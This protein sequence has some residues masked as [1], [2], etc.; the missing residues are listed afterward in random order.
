MQHLKPWLALTAAML[1][2][3]VAQADTFKLVTLE[4]PP[5]EYTENGEV[6]GLAVEVVRAAFK[7]MNH[8]VV[9]ESYPWARSQRMFEQG[10]ADGIFTYFKN[11]Q[12]EEYA[13]FGKEPVV[14][15]TVSLW[16]LRDSKI[17]FTGDLNK[18]QSY[19]FGVVNT[20]S[21]G[22]RF[23]AAVKYELLRTDVAHSIESCISKL[24]AGRTDIW[25][26]NRFGAIHELKRFGKLDQV[27]E[28]KLPV[29]EVPAYVGFSKLRNHTALRDAFD[30]ALATLKQTGAY[31]KLVKKYAE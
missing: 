1:F 2:S 30:Q 28:L 24:L 10:Q 18:L 20:V 12:R 7:L 27:K 5:Y 8:E 29:Q 15:Q 23:D 11:P 16:V 14:T 4:Y 25:V 19:S 3:V 26:S 17:E 22:E 21:Y 13:L 6:K 9:I 31:D